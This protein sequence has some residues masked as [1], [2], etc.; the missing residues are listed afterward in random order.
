[1]RGSRPGT[2][3]PSIGLSGLGQLPPQ[4]RNSRCKEDGCAR[5]GVVEVVSQVGTTNAGGTTSAP[6]VLL[7]GGAVNLKEVL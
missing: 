3:I 5:Y 1:M 7:Q 6:L 2:E 4:E